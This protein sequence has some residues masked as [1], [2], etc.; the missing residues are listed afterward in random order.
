MARSFAYTVQIEHPV[1]CFQILSF[2]G[3]FRH[4]PVISRYFVQFPAK[5]WGRLQLQTPHPHAP[6]AVMTV[7]YAKLPQISRPIRPSRP[8]QNGQNSVFYTKTTK[9]QVLKIRLQKKSKKTNRLRVR[10]GQTSKAWPA[11]RPAGRPAGQGSLSSQGVLGVSQGQTME[12]DEVWRSFSH[13]NG[14]IFD[15][16]VTIRASRNSTWIEA[17]TQQ[18]ATKRNI[19]CKTDPSFPA[20]GV[21]MTVVYINSLKSLGF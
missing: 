6:G 10:H 13:Q 19:L 18:N 8:S 2:P 5:W 3:Y 17:E 20:P 16:G 14:Q 1:I 11:G 12:I 7:V 15:R 4:F 9:M 21:R